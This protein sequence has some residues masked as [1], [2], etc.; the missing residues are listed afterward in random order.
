[1]SL[2]PSTWSYSSVHREKHPLLS[3]WAFSQALS[4]LLTWIHL[5]LLFLDKSLTEL[6]M[7]MEHKLSKPQPHGCKSQHIQYMQAFWNTDI[8]ISTRM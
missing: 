7:E 8:I 5:F 3:S 4:L 1:M 2:I 6:T